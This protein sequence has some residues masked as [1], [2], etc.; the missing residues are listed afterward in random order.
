MNFQENKIDAILK[1][2][3]PSIGCIDSE[4]IENSGS[5]QKNDCL[6][7]VKKGVFCLCINWKLC[8]YNQIETES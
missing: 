3:D 2:A 4:S 1:H 6:R 7:K 5:D 8:D